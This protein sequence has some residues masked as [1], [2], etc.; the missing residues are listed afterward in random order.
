MRNVNR[1]GRVGGVGRFV[2]IKTGGWRR[3]GGSRQFRLVP[4]PA[5][6]VGKELCQV[7]VCDRS[8]ACRTSEDSGRQRGH[9]ADQLWALAYL[10]GL[11][12]RPQES[13]LRERR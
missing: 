4:I 8:I 9:Q 3:R 5:P 12:F 6:H 11:V 10:R 7:T 1:K 2:Q 13:R